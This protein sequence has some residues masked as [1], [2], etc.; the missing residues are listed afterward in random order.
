MKDTLEPNLQ[1][2]NSSMSETA[3]EPEGTPANITEESKVQKETE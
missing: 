1:A 3:Q 2:E